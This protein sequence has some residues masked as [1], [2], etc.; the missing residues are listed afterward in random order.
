M[1]SNTSGDYNLAIGIP[2][3]GGT[4]TAASTIKFAFKYDGNGPEQP[5]GGL[6]PCIDTAVEASVTVPVVAQYTP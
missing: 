6:T 5:S 2:G 1:A 3:P 4:C